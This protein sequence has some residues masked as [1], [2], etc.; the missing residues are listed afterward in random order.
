MDYVSFEPDFDNIFVEEVDLPYGDQKFLKASFGPDVRSNTLAGYEVILVADTVSEKVS[1]KDYEG[2]RLV[3]LITRFPRN[4]LAEVNT[5]RVFSRNSAS[6]R[7]RSIK[8]TIG[9]VMTKP[10]IPLFTR[11]QKGMS[12]VFLSTSD[13]EK[14]IDVW[15]NA[16]NSAVYHALSL[17]LGD[18]MP[19]DGS[20]SDI[21]MNYSE[22][23]DLYYEKVYDA[24]A[25]DTAAISA[26]KQ[27]VNRLLE[28]FSWH[29]AIITSSYWE[30]FLNLRTDLSAA[31]PE[32]VA[33]AKLV[34]RLLD[35]SVPDVSWVHL[36]FV[37]KNEIPAEVVSFADIREV[38]MR[39]ATEAAQ[40]SYRDK[41][42]AT[43]STAKASLGERLLA[44]QHLS[45]FEHVA[46]DSD[47]YFN[48]AE[49]GLPSDKNKLVSN[50][51]P[52]W[53]Q[54]RHVLTVKDN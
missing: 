42:T 46:I 27:N 35:V 48:A 12:G 15:L 14:A 23:V 1:Q 47:T 39:S 4:V 45:P 40:V 34:E 3:T 21:V 5:H 8:S 25:P 22:L 49:D 29:E 2:K 16:R 28:P 38:S 26:H 11:N 18:L 52:K 44:M 33:L 37:D 9:D 36:P 43:K 41:A 10:Y 13:R 54:L 31:Q 6:S 17:L 53:V 19:V 32:I 20:V 51:G 7:A 50:L 30:N 24:D